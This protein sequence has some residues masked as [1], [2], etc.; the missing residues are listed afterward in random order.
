MGMRK[1]QLSWSEKELGS[2]PPPP[3]PKTIS[4]EYS[5]PLHSPPVSLI[6][7]LSS[8]ECSSKSVE[9]P[10]YSLKHTR[11]CIMPGCSTH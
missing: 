4:K 5:S 3:T 7:F 8:W 2:T 11:V 9:G 1:L 10:W 6:S